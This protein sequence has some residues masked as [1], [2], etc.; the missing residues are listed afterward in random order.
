VYFPFTAE[1]AYIVARYALNYQEFSQ[2]H[3]NN[4][5]GASALTSPLHAVLELVL[6]FFFPANIVVSWKILAAGL[7]IASMFLVRSMIEDIGCRLFLYV[8]LLWSAQNVLW[9]VGGLETHLLQFLLACVTYLL[10][11]NEQPE[12][13]AKTIAL[14][15]SLAFLTR[16]D[17]VI[18]LLPINFYLLWCLRRDPKTM[19]LTVL[20]GAA[21]PFVWFVYSYYNFDHILPTS[22]YRKTPGIFFDHYAAYTLVGL[23]F[24][25]VIPLILI[26]RIKSIKPSVASRLKLIFISLILVLIYLVV[27]GK[28]HMMFSSRMLVPYLPVALFAL[29]SIVG[30]R[31]VYLALLAGVFSIVQ[32]VQLDSTYSKGINYPVA[33]WLVDNIEKVDFEYIHT[34]IPEY[35]EFM[36]LLERQSEI[37]EKDWKTEGIDR[38]PVIYSYAEGIAAF[39]YSGAYFE[40]SLVS[41]GNCRY[42]DYTMVLNWWGPITYR[43]PNRKPLFT[44]VLPFYMLKS[45]RSHQ[46]FSVF[47][48]SDLNADDQESLRKVVERCNALDIL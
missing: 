1:D 4:T 47:K 8:G 35:V 17:V 33:S 15:S 26:A 44:E 48:T 45:S 42:P 7:A 27:A 2:F 30:V 41:I 18:F 31:S 9:S 20:F 13:R 29:L 43:T 46:R 16:F 36:A 34:S 39:K 12:A 10:F 25:G 3:Y 38:P 5:P 32:A 14:V 11:S 19:A 21:L 22:F 23:L 40:G 37:I 28:A 24:T 6:S